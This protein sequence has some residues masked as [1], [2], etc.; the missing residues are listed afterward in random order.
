VAAVKPV[1]GHGLDR[2]STVYAVDKSLAMALKNGIANSILDHTIGMFF[3][4][5]HLLF[6]NVAYFHRYLSFGFS[7]GSSLAP[8]TLSISKNSPRPSIPSFPQT[9]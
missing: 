2:Y 8:V 3:R 1:Q 4:Q 9:G 7:V 6:K 5:T